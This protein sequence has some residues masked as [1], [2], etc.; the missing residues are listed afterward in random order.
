[1]KKKTFKF[2]LGEEL[3][4]AVTGFKGVVVIRMDH[5][6]GC[7]SYVI[8]PRGVDKDNKKF[9]TGNFDVTRLKSTG[10]KITVPG[11]EES[12]SKGGPREEVPDRI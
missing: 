1:M 4:D 7:D 10:E 6:S 8:Q 2:E 11:M 9:D 5:I 3:E 12:K